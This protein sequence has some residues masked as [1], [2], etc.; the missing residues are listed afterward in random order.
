MTTPK[1]K[2]RRVQV[3]LGELLPRLRREA[4]ELGIPLATYLRSIIHRRKAVA[5]PKQ[6]A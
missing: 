1:N 3:E 2:R 5:Y 6:A 4:A